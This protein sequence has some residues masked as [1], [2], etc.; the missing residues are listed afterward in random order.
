MTWKIEQIGKLPK[1]KNPVLIEGLPGIGNVGKVS[2]DFIVEELKAKKLFNFFSYTFPHSVFVNE[3]NLVE[4]PNISIYYKKF[5][6]GKKRDLLFLVGDVQPIDE[7]SSYEFTEIVLNICQ[8]LKCKEIVT[9]GGIGLQTIPKKPKVY[10]TGNDKK[11][12]KRYYNK[13]KKD[14]HERLYGVV[15]P[16]IGI[17]GLLLGLS[18]KRKISAIGL[19]AETFAHPMF[20]GI[21]GSKKILKIL[22]NMFSMNLKLQKLEKEIKEMES[23]ILK[24]TDELAKVSKASAMGKLRGKIGKEVN[25]IG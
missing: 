22:N 20:L 6:N 18:Q 14:L 11:I 25:Y 10:C 16:I 19:L 3:E 15:G 5:S 1:L 2:V 13:N 23:E 21:K 17:T 8:N 4:L 9:L 7:T 24:R 12:I